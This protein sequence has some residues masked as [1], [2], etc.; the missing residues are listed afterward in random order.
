MIDILLQKGAKVEYSDPFIIETHKTR[1]NDFKM[2]SIELNKDTI[3]SYDL[4]L[5][6]TD[7]DDFDY[8][9]IEKE[10]K[11]IVDTRGKFNVSKKVIKA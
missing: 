3:N 2:K 7:H 4:V 5:L 9:L 10:S 1:K 6:A 8:N 11:L